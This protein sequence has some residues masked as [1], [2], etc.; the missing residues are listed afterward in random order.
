MYTTTYEI[1]LPTG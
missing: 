1:T